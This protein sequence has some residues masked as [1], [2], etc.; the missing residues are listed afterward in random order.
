MVASVIANQNSLP[1]NLHFAKPYAHNDDDS[2]I[3]IQFAITII[4]V[5]FN[6]IK[7]PLSK[8]ALKP[9][10]Q[11]DAGKIT[12]GTSID[13]CLVIKH[14]KSKTT[15]GNKKKIHKRVKKKY[16]IEL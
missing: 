10:K 12:I 16:L 4:K 5:F 15:N 9:S 8:A 13:S 6:S 3:A 11:S 1:I 14:F 2:G 7:N